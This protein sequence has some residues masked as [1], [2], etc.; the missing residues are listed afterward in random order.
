MVSRRGFLGWSLPACSAWYSA[1]AGGWP[2]SPARAA[3]ILQ[4]LHG[5]SPDSGGAEDDPFWD[6]VAGAFAIDRS[7]INLNNGGVS[8]S[9]ATVQ[10][11]LM[12]H[13]DYSNQAPCHTMWE[14]LEPRREQ[15][16]QRFAETFGCD[17]EEVALTRNASEGLQTCQF[18]LELRRGDEVLTTNQDYPRMINTF[19]QREQRE[20]I[21]LRQF[22]IPVPAEDPSYIVA[23]FEENIT[24]RTRMILVSHVV[25]LTGQVLPVA[26]VVALG[27]SRGIPV[28]VDGAHALAHL[29][30][31]IRDLDCDYY[32]SSLHKWLFAPHGTGMLYVRREQIGGLWPLMAAPPDR[33]TNI[34]KFEEIGTH[35]AANYLAIDEALSFHHALGPTRKLARLTWLRD[36]WAHRLL[37]HERVR[38]H[39]SLRPGLAGAIATFQVEGVDTT[40]LRDWLW[41]EHRILTS[42]IVHEEFQGLRVSPSVCTRPQELDRFCDAVEHVLRHGLPSS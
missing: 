9:P 29:D 25:F 1:L 6:M 32:A 19:R 7:I 31:K 18:G 8:S 35:P 24:P 40:A 36:Y 3:E 28:I 20:G 37:Q 4:T 27:R 38:L 41:A 21:V 15:V 12:R 39:T 13:L 30:F 16:R 42:P 22:S 10:A 11:A 2:L 33:S 26:E 34:R 23:L 5:A 17:A 14:V